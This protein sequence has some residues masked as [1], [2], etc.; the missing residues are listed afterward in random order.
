MG[1][2][3]GKAKPQR[4]HSTRVIRTRLI[5]EQIEAAK[6]H[7]LSGSLLGYRLALILLDN[8]AE[9]IM[10]RALLS[11]FA[12]DDQLMPTWEPARTEWINL[13]YGP[14]YSADERRRAHSDFLCKTRILCLR[15][16][17]I[18]DEDRQ[19]LDV[20]HK[21]RNEAFHQGKLRDAILGGVSCLL[22]TTVVG[23][24]IKLPVR[25]FMLPHPK[26]PSEDA[27][28]MQR[29]GL[30]H[31]MMLGSDKGRE[32]CASHLLDGIALETAFSDMLSEDLL[33]RIDETIGGL[34]YVT[35]ARDDI[36]LD[37]QLQYTQFWRATGAKLM[38][39]GVR[40]PDLESA[41]NRWRTQGSATFTLKK[42]QRWKNQAD[43]IQLC[44][45]PATALSHYWGVDKRLRPLEEDVRN[46]VWHYDQEI[47]AQIH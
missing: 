23:L 42:I 45:V 21:F 41:F 36:H 8:S 34:E 15:L 1:R 22:Y 16:N 5:Y 35:H 38:K 7:L 40:E 2:F 25:S 9:I 33:E 19:V 12:F 11:K 44:S 28:F 29:F 3:T 27:G 20:C 6:A 31:A 30:S 26:R 10:H 37:R 39:E 17:E 43:A 18:S 4:L 47:D 32:Q 46:S 14:K 13:G 24:T